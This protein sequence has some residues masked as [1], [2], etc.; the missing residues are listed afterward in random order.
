MKF[1]RDTKFTEFIV[2]LNC[3]EFKIAELEIFNPGK[4]TRKQCIQPVHI[5]PL[6]IFT[7]IYGRNFLTLHSS[8]VRWKVL[9][10]QIVVVTGTVWLRVFVLF[11]SQVKSKGVNWHFKRQSEMPPITT[12]VTLS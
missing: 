4:G 5:C 1:S 10:Y 11:R 7:C 2:S 9:L 8:S 3:C 6:K 12:K